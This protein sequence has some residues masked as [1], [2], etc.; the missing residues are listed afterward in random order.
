V[1]RAA[2]ARHVDAGGTVHWIRM[3]G[4][5]QMRTAYI[6]PDAAPNLPTR[7][8]VLG[9][10]P[11][12]RELILAAIDIPALFARLARSRLMRLLLDEVKLVPTLP[13]HLPRPT[14]GTCA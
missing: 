4:H 7:C 6:R 9:I 10:S 13:L 14:D 8:T 12:L 11:L 5:V 3:V 1:D 2:H